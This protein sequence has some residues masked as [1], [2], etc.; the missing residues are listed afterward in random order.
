MSKE[1]YNKEWTELNKQIQ[2]LNEKR[3]KIYKRYK[4]KY[5]T[6]N[7]KIERNVSLYYDF[8]GIDIDIKRR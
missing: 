4:D 5:G 7:L 8:N 3:V 6:L 2:A 1:E